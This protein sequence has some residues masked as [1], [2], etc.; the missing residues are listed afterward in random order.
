[1]N[2]IEYAQMAR[3]AEHRVKPVGQHQLLGHLDAAPA[4]DD[5]KAI[6]KNSHG[7][8]TKVAVAK[9]PVDR[10]K[11]RALDCYRHELPDILRHWETHPHVRHPLPEKEG[12]LTN[13]HDAAMR[14]YA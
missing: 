2:I 4:E 3:V 8:G 1:M 12:V 10:L 9:G 5:T 6:P 11:T 7:P 14:Y 13:H